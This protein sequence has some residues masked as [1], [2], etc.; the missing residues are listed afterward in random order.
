MEITEELEKEIV[1]FYWVQ[2]GGSASVC[3]SMRHRYLQEIFDTRSE[4]GFI[5]NGYDWESLAR[6]FLDE[7][8]PGL[9]EKI[10]FDPEADLFCVYSEDQGAL[11]E[12]IRQFRKACED[13]TLI[14]DLF[15][16]AE[17]D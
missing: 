7:Q 17:L 2:Q 5:G 16:R 13:R 8:C 9:Q 6:V 14:L 11:I 15:C 1:P 3:L 12:F 4:E 10:S